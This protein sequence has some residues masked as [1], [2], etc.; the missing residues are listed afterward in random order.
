MT[1]QPDSGLEAALD[2]AMAAQPDRHVSL[3]YW[4][5]AI[6]R[7]AMRR[8]LAAARP[9]LVA[10]ERQWQAAAHVSVQRARQQIRDA[11]QRALDDFGEPGR[12]AEALILAEVQDCL[13]DI[14][15]TIPE[16]DRG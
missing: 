9:H 7:A 12:R 3:G 5:P 14:D 4:E 8:V 2:V 10:G 15:Q 13:D 6:G 16:A 1:A 11:T